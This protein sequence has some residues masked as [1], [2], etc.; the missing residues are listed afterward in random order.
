M[1]PHLAYRY[2]ISLKK[3]SLTVP[4]LFAGCLMTRVRLFI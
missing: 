2:E 3:A 4:F 1:A